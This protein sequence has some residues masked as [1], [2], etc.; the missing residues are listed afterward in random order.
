MK[1]LLSR[2]STVAPTAVAATTHGDLSIC[3]SMRDSAK[4]KSNWHHCE[5]QLLLY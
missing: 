5:W 1:S 3:N 2:P 4:S